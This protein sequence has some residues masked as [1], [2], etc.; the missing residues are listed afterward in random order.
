MYFLTH[1]RFSLP[2]SV[3]RPILIV[4]AGLLTGKGHES[5]KTVSAVVG[6]SGVGR[7]GVRIRLSIRVSRELQAAGPWRL[8]APEGDMSAVTESG[9]VTPRKALPATRGGPY[10]RPR[11]NITRAAIVTQGLKPLK[12]RGGSIALNRFLFNQK[13]R[14]KKSKYYD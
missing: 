12:G 5:S 9:D 2:V 1:P 4:R 6:D 10:L 13:A 8:Q 3:V 11:W 14:G 7:A